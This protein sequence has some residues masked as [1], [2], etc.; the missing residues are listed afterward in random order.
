MYHTYTIYLL[1]SSLSRESII[2]FKGEEVEEEF[3]QSFESHKRQMY[4]QMISALI[5]S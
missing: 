1:S 3:C 4:W 2:V 5:P